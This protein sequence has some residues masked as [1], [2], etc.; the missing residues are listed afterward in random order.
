[1]RHVLARRIFLLGLVLI[2]LAVGNVAA[3][4]THRGFDVK[5]QVSGSA[6]AENI[7]K[8]AVSATSPS[9]VS[10]LN[11]LRFG[12]TTRSGYFVR[13]EI[14]D[15]A[16]QLL[17]VHGLGRDV[18]IASGAKDVFVPSGQAGVVTYRVRLRPGAELTVAPPVRATILP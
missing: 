2:S 9:G 18:R 6:H 11:Q 16:V 14:E 12:V 17:E 5:V 15:P 1:M 8:S 3:R 7:P 4:R 13:F 10:P